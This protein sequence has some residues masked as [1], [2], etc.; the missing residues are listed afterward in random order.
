[1][2]K[3]TSKKYISF[4]IGGGGLRTIYFAGL[5]HGITEILK[6]PIKRITVFSG[7][8][9]V[10]P[11]YLTSRKKIKELVDNL[12]INEYLDVVADDFE[13]AIKMHGVIDYN[14]R[15]NKFMKSVISRVKSKYQIYVVTYLYKK[16]KRLYERISLDSVKDSTRLPGV[17]VPGLRYNDYVFDGGIKTHIPYHLFE[18]SKGKNELLISMTFSK[19]TPLSV[20]NSLLKLT[21]FSYDTIRKIIHVSRNDKLVKRA[22]ERFK[23]YNYLPEYKRAKKISNLFINAIVPFSMVPSKVILYSLF[24]KGYED[25]MIFKDRIKAILDAEQ[26]N[27]DLTSITTTALV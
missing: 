27:P 21:N 16:N 23:N 6:L 1:M 24:D 9:L 7:S 2:V 10:I 18:K 12:E 8:A 25:A 20:L 26:T 22:L 17:F 14:E 13:S 19:S 11:A 3:R 5:I 4:A 15:F